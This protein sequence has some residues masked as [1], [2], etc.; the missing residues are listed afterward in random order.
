MGGQD[1]FATAV[2]K[3]KDHGPVVE[4]TQDYNT[5]TGVA[6]PS[7]SNDHE[8]DF[9]TENEDRDL[10]RGLEQRHISLIAIAGAI[11]TGLFL[12]LG[13]SIQTAGPLGA[14]KIYPIHTLLT[15]ANASSQFLA[16]QPSVSS[17]ALSN[18]HWEKS[19]PSCP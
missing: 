12:G 9:V 18:L 4:V 11:G 14:R 6:G 17:S 3:S 13:S 19:L 7:G 10:N 15:C 2:G 16:M 1:G 8:G 5:F